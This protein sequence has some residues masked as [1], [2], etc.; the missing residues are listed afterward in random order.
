[1]SLWSS[2]LQVVCVLGVVDGRDGGES[3]EGLLQ[4]MAVK[5]SDT[6]HLNS[7]ILLSKLKLF[8]DESKTKTGN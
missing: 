5:N 3:L 2:C 1:M 4:I 6:P 7:D 8:V